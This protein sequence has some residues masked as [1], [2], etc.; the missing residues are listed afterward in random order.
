[1]AG[2]CSA[3]AHCGRATASQ[4]PQPPGSLRSAGLTRFAA[5]FRTCA[6]VFCAPAATGC[7]DMSAPDSRPV[8][9]FGTMRS[10][11]LAR[12]CIEHDS[13]LRVAGFTVDQAYAQ[14]GE[15]EGLPLVAFEALEQRFP[16]AEYRLLIP[17]GYQQMNGVRRD[18]YEQ[19]SFRGYSFASYVS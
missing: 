13:P 3:S 2:R 10:A 7:P 9:I 8:V 19:A 1:M 15:Y 12:Y 11:S 18:R 6:S 14:A 16:P 5:V 4:V 17:M